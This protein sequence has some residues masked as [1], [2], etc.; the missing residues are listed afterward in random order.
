MV[1]YSTVSA[2]LPAWAS[3]RQIFPAQAIE[4]QLVLPKQIH[5]L[6]RCFLLKTCTKMERMIIVTKSTLNFDT[7]SLQ[8]S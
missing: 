4:T 8:Y 7:L 5:P 1:F 3:A 2:T 6:L